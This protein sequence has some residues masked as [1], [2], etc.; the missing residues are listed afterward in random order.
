MK[1]RDVQ[2]DLRKNPDS[3]RV[4]GLRFPVSGPSH[5]EQKET[6]R[7]EEAPPGNAAR[8]LST[9]ELPLR[10]APSRATGGRREDP[11]RPPNRRGSSNL[12]ARPRFLGLRPHAQTITGTITCLSPRQI[13]AFPRRGN[14]RLGREPPRG[15]SCYLTARLHWETTQNKLGGPSRLEGREKR[16]LEEVSSK[17]HSSS[18]ALVGGFGWRAGGRM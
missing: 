18:A 11:G 7:E 12:A 10:N 3:P 4:H 16:W 17:V 8:M 14:R 13:L 5:V 6:Q 1:P 15:S 2:F 9:F